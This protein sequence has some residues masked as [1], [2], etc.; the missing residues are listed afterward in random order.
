M[1][2]WLSLCDL[3]FSRIR[4]ANILTNLIVVTTFEFIKGSGPAL[5]Q[6]R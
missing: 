6:A 4:G 3:F 1:I 5:T 2:F